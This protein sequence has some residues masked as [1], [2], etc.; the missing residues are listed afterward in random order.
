MNGKEQNYVEKILKDYQGKKNDKVEELRELDRK[1]KQPA[2]IFAYIFGTI[3]ALILGFG[4]CLAME[5][6]FNL[7]PLGIIIGVVGI[8]MVCANYFLYEKI[9][10]SRKNKYAD[11]IIELSRDI[12]HE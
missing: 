8:I 5:V 2:V 12:L 7:M 3:G 11:R 9:L 4:M 10:Q 1:V 6:L